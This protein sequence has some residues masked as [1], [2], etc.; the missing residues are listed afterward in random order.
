MND[1]DEVTYDIS[2]GLEYIR[3]HPEVTNVLLTGGDPMILQT[4][5][6]EKIFASLREIDHLKIIRI[7]S[8]MPAFNPF[9]FTNDP[10]LMDLFKNYS[11][12]E[13][14]IYM[15]CHYDHPCE[16]TEESREAIGYVN[17]CRCYLR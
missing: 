17:R 4:P 1:N 15:M 12:P 8:K 2:S 10:A 6:L 7:G 11:T 16:L 5:K 14:R 9:R 3:N 13:K